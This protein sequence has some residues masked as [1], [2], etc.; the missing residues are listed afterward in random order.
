MKGATEAP[1]QKIILRQ[2]HDIVQQIG[3][4]HST[5]NNEYNN[6]AMYNAKYNNVATYGTYDSI[7]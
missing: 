1:E 7:R 4:T 2:V 3:F 5:C 6:V